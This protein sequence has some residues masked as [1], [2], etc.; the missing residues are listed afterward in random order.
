MS[1]PI[2]TS[3]LRAKAEAVPG[4]GSLRIQPDILIALLDEVDRLRAVPLAADNPAAVERAMAAFVKCHLGDRAAIVAALRAAQVPASPDKAGEICAFCRRPET[5]VLTLIKSQQTN[6]IICAEC[7]TAC[8]LVT[9]PG[10]LDHAGEIERLR[11]E[12][13]KC[14]EGSRY[15][16]AADG[17]GHDLPHHI[18]ELYYQRN[19]AIA[20]AEKAERER[21]EVRL[22][23]S[24]AH[25]RSYQEEVV[26][27]WQARIDAAIAQ[28]DRLAEALRDL[29]GI[30][31]EDIV[32]RGDPASYGCD[33]CSADAGEL[34][35]ND[36]GLET[37]RA[38]I[39]SAGAM[40]AAIDQARKDAPAGGE[41]S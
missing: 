34:C 32:E 7:A 26:P 37:Q 41:K 21:D 8:S 14:A 17:H 18:D 13:A 12:L 30:A 31:N 9:T 6:A 4:F 5:A 22:E 10:A 25:A 33:C 2:N 20:R 24:K 36:C 29:H 39:D 19:E 1:D 16:P 23:T 27:A 35:R 40:L 3:D 28:R 38:M 15:E 11:Q